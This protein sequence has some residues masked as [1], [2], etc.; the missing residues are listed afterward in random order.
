MLGRSRSTDEISR[1]LADKM[2]WL[3]GTIERRAIRLKRRTTVSSP[4]QTREVEFFEGLEPQK[5]QLGSEHDFTGKEA[6]PQIPQSI[7]FAMLVIECIRKQRSAIRGTALYS[8]R[9]LLGSV[10]SIAH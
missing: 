3:E 8:E 5:P 9:R 6:S 1:D 10:F 4:P 2:D 7:Q